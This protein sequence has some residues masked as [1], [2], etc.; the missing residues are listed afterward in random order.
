MRQ[1]NKKVLETIFEENMSLYYDKSDWL[2]L[3][4][5]RMKS[6]GFP[7]ITVDKDRGDIDCLVEDWK[8]FKTE[9]TYI[10]NVSNRYIAKKNAE[11]S[12]QSNRTE[13]APKLRRHRGQDKENESLKTANK[14][15]DSR[16]FNPS[17][18]I[19]GQLLQSAH[20]N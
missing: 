6:N 7:I 2:K 17:S 18:K 4:R 11:T 14:N 9:M 1:P 19:I 12:I 16:Q 20:T 15:T 8:S 5:D 13:D 10:L 3:C